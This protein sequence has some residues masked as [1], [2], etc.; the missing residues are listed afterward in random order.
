MRLDLE[1]IDMYKRANRTNKTKVD[2]RIKVY[3]GDA[4]LADKE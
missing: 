3:Y 2:R 4:D 1:I